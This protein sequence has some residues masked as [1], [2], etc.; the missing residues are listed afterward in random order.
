MVANHAPK[1]AAL[2]LVAGIA[3]T[4]TAF[5]ADDVAS[6]YSGKRLKMIAAAGVGGGYDMYA[7]LLARHLPDHI[8]G[9]PTII[10]QN[11][12][13]AGGIVGANFL[14]NATQ[15][16]GT[17]I[18]ALQ[19]ESALVQIMGKSG[20]KFRSEQFN[21]LGSL[22]N[23]AGVC[24]FRTATG[25]K[26]FDDVF[27][28]TFSVGSTG[29]NTTEYFPALFNNLLGARFNLVRGYPSTSNVHIALERGELDGVCQS[30]SSLK[31]LGRAALKA[32]EMK[33]MLQV[34]LKPDPEMDKLGV[35]MVDK[36]I[37][38]D[39]LAHGR[40][41]AD[42]KTYF[43][44]VLAPEAMGRPYALAP[45]VPEARVKAMRAAF[46]ATAKDPKFLAEAKKLRRDIQLVTGEEI[47]AIV[48]ELAGTPKTKLDE[49]QDLLKFK[50]PTKQ[51][52]IVLVHASG[53]VVKSVKG[54]RE[55]VIDSKGH[56]MA[57]KIS[58]SHTKVM[59]DGKKAKRGAVTAGMTCTF[60]YYGP[61]T[62]AKEL[63]CNN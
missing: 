26:S 17:T 47:Q 16:D 60:A 25:I 19:R 20:P 40:T 46:E 54:G 30:W 7:R 15:K 27:A 42:V 13:G 58:G 8:P 52:K 32:G 5:A 35:P 41:V 33:P 12:A 11:M 10:V 21:W 36:Y 23:E 62:E 55:I 14:F 39:H 51:V 43:K 38:A 29:E 61:G 2:A 48:S 28:R 18:G 37:D 57:A 9:H 49:L 3:V 63:S 31:E 44:I 50:G 6:F 59:I 24:A 56:N 4:A 34:S 45:G 1:S 53:K 22:A